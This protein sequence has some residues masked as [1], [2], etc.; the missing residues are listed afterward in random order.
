LNR[1]STDYVPARD[2]YEVLWNV[3]SEFFAD[4]PKANDYKLFI[5]SN[6]ERVNDYTLKVDS[7]A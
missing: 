1:I 2:E 4:F 5:P 3:F 6:I 7:T